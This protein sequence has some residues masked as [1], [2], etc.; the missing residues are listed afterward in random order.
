M[1]SRPARFRCPK[2]ASASRG[3]ADN[4]A[5][6]PRPRPVL[7][8]PS[9]PRRALRRPLLR[10]G[11]A[12]RGIYCRPGLHGRRRRCASNCRFFPSAAA[13]E[14]RRVPP[15]PALPAR[16]RARQRHASTPTAASRRPRRGTDRGRAPGGREPRRSSPARSASPTGTCAASSSSEFGVSPV[17]YAQTQRLLLAKRLLT[18]TALPVI[19][20]AFA[21]GFA[22]LRRFNDLFRTR[23]R[24]TPGQLR[25]AAR[26][27]SGRRTGLSFDLAFRPPYD[28]PAM[29]AFLG[30][31]A[32]AGVE[33]VDGRRYRRSVCLE[34]AGKPHSGWIEVAPSPRKSALR[35]T[36][37]ASLAGA[38]PPLL[39]RVKSLPRPRLPTRRDRAG[40]GPARGGDIR[41]C[42]CPAPS[43]ASRSRC[44]R[45]SAS[46]SPSPPRRRSPGASR[47][48][49]ASPFD[50]PHAGA[51]RASSRPPRAIADAAPADIAA[52]GVIAARAHAPSSRSRAPSRPATL[53]L[54]PSAPSGGHARR[55]RGAARRRPVDRAVHRHARA[56]LAGRLPAPRPRRA[57]GDAAR[58]NAARACSQRAK[59]GGPGAPTPCC[60]SGNPWRTRTQRTDH[61]PLRPPRDARSAPWSPIAAGGD[62]RGLRLRRRASTRRAIGP[63]W[64]EDPHGPPLREC[65]AQLA[66]YFAGERARFDLPARAARHAVPARACGRRSPRCPTAR[67]SRYAELAQRAGV[68]R[69]GPRRRRRHGPQPARHRR[70]LPPHRGARTARSPDT[71]AGLARKARLLQLE[72]AAVE[73]AA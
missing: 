57:E 46:R 47:R 32:I 24:M 64:S 44:A 56:R 48:R 50:T 31:R 23:Y 42:A 72:G 54:E 34:R 9:H 45:S 17:E 10:G 53:R 68:P 12:R 60:T 16:A 15:V 65:A 58:P 5:H 61:D 71:P 51:R 18:D 19:E 38:V 20:V 67:R 8:G 13:A 3:A 21:S 70:A 30:R 55:A 25:K 28:W 62:A 66:E 4:A 52:L 14:A 6:D 22:S 37:S 63:A 43:T 73:A 33:A 1:P 49:S 40:A 7:P 69:L 36:A 11:G 26:A 2:T 39:A 41:A 59:P 27:R 35:V 29:L